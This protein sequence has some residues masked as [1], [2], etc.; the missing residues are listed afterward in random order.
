ML[1]GRKWALVCFGLSYF[2]WFLLALV[3][4][5]SA[6]VFGAAVGNAGALANVVLLVEIAA[7]AVTFAMVMFVGVYAAV[8]QAVFYRDVKAE[9]EPARGDTQ[10]EAAENSIS[11]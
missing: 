5:L 2:G 1:Y 7:L 10:P 11:G 6:R 9:V 3:P 4:V 8:G